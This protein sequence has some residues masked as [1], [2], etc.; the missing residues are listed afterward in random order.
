[1]KRWRLR[2]PARD[3]NYNFTAWSHH[4][5]P[6]RHFRHLLLTPV[7]ATFQRLLFPD[8]LAVASVAG[9]LTYYNTVVAPDAAIFLSSPVP[10]TL[11]S[12]AL[13]L[14]LVFRTNSSYQRYDTA[15][16][17]LGRINNNSRALARFAAV[18]AAT[19]PQ[20]ERVLN[21]IRL[22]TRVLVFHLTDDGDL[23][24]L[25]KC[26]PSEEDIKE[27]LQ[28]EVEGLLGKGTPLSRSVLGAGNKPVKV[29]QLMTAAIHDM[30][31]DPVIESRAND[32]ITELEAALGGSERLLLTPIPT[33]Y[34]RH[35]SRFLSF[36]TSC[37]PFALWPYFGAEGTV[38]ASLA[39]AFTML[40]IED[41]GVTVEEPFDLLPMWRLVDAVDAACNLAEGVEGE[42]TASL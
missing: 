39:I 33:S 40:G 36:W 21:L 18:H 4:R 29:L 13:G 19:G 1:M 9:G 17:H 5:S 27:T 41:I 16:G 35:T 23:N 3:N 10:M 42:M 25:S 11:T 24:E 31:L 22:F 20:R 30:G 12:T 2:D 7:S 26:V 38:A 14:L 37:L 6:F 15:R 32:R 34:T 28:A 8:L